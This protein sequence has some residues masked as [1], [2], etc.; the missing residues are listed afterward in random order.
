MAGLFEKFGG[1]IGQAVANKN[2]RRDAA[3]NKRE[4]IEL[5]Q[6][7]DYEPTYASE[8]T[9][10]YQKTKSP[11]ARSYLES[12]LA[13]N[14]PMMTFSG[15]PNAAVTK[16]RQQAAQDQM[17]GTMEQRV[18]AQRAADAETPWKVQ[19]PT[20]PVITEKA[21]AAGFQAQNPGA[22][23]QGLSEEQYEDLVRRGVI[24]PSDMGQ[25]KVMGAMSDKGV[26]ARAYAAG[27]FNAIK[28]ILSPYKLDRPHAVMQNRQ[29]KKR[30]KEIDRL[31]DK[32]DHDT[33]G[34]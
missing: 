31:I 6:A 28:E 23:K 16:Q 25:Q 1:I 30:A 12:F 8:T 14:N 3:K 29:K 18:A 33:W 7:M 26:L 24:N 4:G 17:F 2:N 21:R 20:K 34:G 9:P 11:I 15:A 22:V 10:T 32:Y 5:V 13:G 27:D 19:T